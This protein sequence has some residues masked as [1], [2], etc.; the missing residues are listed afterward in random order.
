[1]TDVLI[2]LNL[3]R[4]PDTFGGR[5]E[6]TMRR[7]MPVLRDGHLVG[8]T[9]P[10]G[11][12]AR[13]VL[14]QLIEAHCH[15]DKCHSVHRM[16]AV[17]GDL[18]QAIATQR[19]DK[20]HWTEDDLHARASRGMAEA[21]RNGC[22]L[23]R[24]HV[25]WGDNSSPPLAWSVLGALGADHGPLQRAALTGVLQWIDSAFAKAVAREIARDNAVLGAFVYDQPGLQAGLSII[26]DMAVR[27]GLPLDF[28]VDEGLGDLN[29]LEAI[30]DTA[31]ATG[32]EGP[33]LCGHAVSL[34]DRQGADLARIIDKLLAARIHI[35]A[36]PTTNLYL[37]GRRD[38]TP[39]RRGL[40][41]LRE[42]HDAGVPIV[43][44]SDNVTDAFCPTGAHDP[45]SALN[46]AIYAAHLDPP[47]AQWLPAI[48]THAATALGADPLH[49]DGAA[50]DA[51][52]LYAADNMSDVL[53]GR[54]AP[55]PARE[56]FG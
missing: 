17:G 30:A 2:P 45:M 39:D 43:V 32:Y 22:G 20:E 48:T 14:P 33:I 8:L 11:G 38:G 25:D 15:L 47:L 10:Q 9:D 5:T 40:T 51:L 21:R 35:C 12:A 41:R 54:A 29:G 23:I 31:I 50:C 19:A 56:A 13:I 18:P 53:S 24:T 7:G 55:Q 49:V 28:H 44:G 4:A 34:I 46:L 42:L 6:G 16:G 1:M 26:F 27:H 52:N 37:Q 3:L 36:L